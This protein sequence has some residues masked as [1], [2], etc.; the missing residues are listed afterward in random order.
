MLKDIKT[1][2]SMVE[3][4]QHYLHETHK[5]ESNDLDAAFDHLVEAK[6]LLE[7]VIKDYENRH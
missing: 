1:S 7:W 2:L 3:A 5:L 6:A 4:A